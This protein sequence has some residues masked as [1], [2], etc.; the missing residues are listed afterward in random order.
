MALEEKQGPA[1]IRDE[2]QS[3]D[4]DAEEEEKKKDDDDD[5]EGTTSYILGINHLISRGDFQRQIFF[6]NFKI[7]SYNGTMP[8]IWPK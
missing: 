5:T 3:V 7:G 6:P 4:I 8:H 1:E 2:L